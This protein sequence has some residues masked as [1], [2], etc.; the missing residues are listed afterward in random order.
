MGGG[1]GEQ[2]SVD[3]GCVDLPGG[4]KGEGGDVLGGRMS[5][6]RDGRCVVGELGHGF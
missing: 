6:L 1:S 4:G 3:E 5:L 2:L